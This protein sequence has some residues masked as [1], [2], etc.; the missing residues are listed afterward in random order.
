MKDREFV[1][2][3]CA[4]HNRLSDIFRYTPIDDPNALEDYLSFNRAIISDEEI[5]LFKLAKCDESD[6]EGKYIRTVEES[7]GLP[8]LTFEERGYYRLSKLQRP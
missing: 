1:L 2:R 4:E 3:V 7:E 6:P 8:C 5:D